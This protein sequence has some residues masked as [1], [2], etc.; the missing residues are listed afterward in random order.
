MDAHTL[1]D[2]Q[3]LVIARQRFV[4][5]VALPSNLLPSTIA[6]SWARSREAGLLPWQS[7]L[8]EQDDSLLPLDE[9]DQQL[10]ECVRPEIDLSLIHI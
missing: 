4:E 8:A 7:W 1:H 9:S 3:R 2:Q 5:G 10:A 6:H